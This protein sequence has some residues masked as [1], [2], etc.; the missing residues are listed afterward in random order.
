MDGSEEGHSARGGRRRRRREARERFSQHEKKKNLGTKPPV[1][2][3]SRRTDIALSG[4]SRAA[5][6]YRCAWN[7][8]I[9]WTLFWTESTPEE[10][11]F[12]QNS[13]TYISGSKPEISDLWS[14]SLI[15]TC[16]NSPREKSLVGNSQFRPVLKCIQVFH[17]RSA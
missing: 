4:V 10:R 2:I 16:K 9:T 7:Q 12:I 8:A 17:C 3:S 14:S 6:W 5:Q 13:M 1:C 15:G 11:K